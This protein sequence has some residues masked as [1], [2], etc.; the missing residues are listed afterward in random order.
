MHKFIILLKKIYWAIS[1][2]LG[3]VLLI[4]DERKSTHSDKLKKY[5][6]IHGIYYLPARAYQDVIRKEI[7]KNRIF[8]K[9]VYNLSKKFIKPNSTIID[10]GANYGQMSILYSKLFSN[11]LV[12]SFEGS[13]FVYD[14]L[15][16]NVEINSKNIKPINCILS[17]TS[18]EKYVI[19]PELKEIGTYGAL[20][21]KFS[22]DTNKTYKEKTLIRKIDDFN[23]EK[24]I[25]FMK[26]DVQGWDLK[27]LKGSINTINENRMPIIFEY[28]NIFEKE[29]QFKLQDYINFFK[30]IDYKF[31]T[32]TDSNFLVLPS[33]YK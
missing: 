21:L 32:N 2:K 25:S 28:E 3:F 4:R 26:I 17:D 23:Y 31:D 33:E 15:V 30:A 27:V 1:K 6:T 8:D 29:I 11:S 12:Y 7:I 20:N 9:K 16:K 13:R 5:N 22:N 10:A 14:I 24:K 18:D 19:K